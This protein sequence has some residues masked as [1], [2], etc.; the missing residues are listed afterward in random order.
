MQ[1]SKCK[2]PKCENEC[3]LY[4]EGDKDVL[5]D[6]CAYHGETEE[7][8]KEV[9]DIMKSSSMQTL[10]EKTVICPSCKGFDVS[11]RRWALRKSDPWTARANFM[12]KF[13]MLYWDNFGAQYHIDEHDLDEITMKLWEYAKK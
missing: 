1:T 6:Y 13:K 11:L 2:I 5:S 10:E 9:K 7:G 4:A 8:Q 12:Q 3:E